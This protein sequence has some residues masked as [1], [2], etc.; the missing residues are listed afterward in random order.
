M[1]IKQPLIRHGE[2]V[3]DT[4]GSFVN[5][6]MMRTITDQDEPVVMSPEQF[7]QLSQ[8]LRDPMPSAGPDEFWFPY[9]CRIRIERP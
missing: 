7:H 5:L 4:T 9:G 8:C 2:I 6:D 1:S 3:L